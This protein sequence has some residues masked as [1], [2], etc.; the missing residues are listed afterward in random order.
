MILDRITPLILTRNEEANIGRTLTQLTWAREVVVVDS[1]SSD[2]TVEIARR[3]ANVRVVQREFDSHDRQW[4]FGVEQVTTP[5]VLTLDAD[6]FVPEAIVREMASLDP[7]PDLAAYSAAFVYAID[8]HPLRATL[9]TP[10]E[11]LLR[12]G[13]FEIWQDGHTQ[14]VRVN[15]RVERLREWI[16]HDDRKDLRRF[17]DRQKSY[18]R[19]EAAKLRATSWSALPIS[20]RIRKLRVV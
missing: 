14:R 6:Y 16:I 9:Y 17:I 18:M 12:R 13:A 4:S 20:G 2:A 3:F 7:P 1:M 15:G 5:W 10:R 11:V 8:G 19:K